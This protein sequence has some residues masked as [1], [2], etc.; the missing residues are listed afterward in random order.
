MP[1]LHNFY[2]ILP[3]AEPCCCVLSQTLFL[4]SSEHARTKFRLKLATRISSEAWTESFEF[5]END[6]A[7]SFSRCYA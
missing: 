4:L 3:A 2:F 6:A 5:N 1:A 7:I